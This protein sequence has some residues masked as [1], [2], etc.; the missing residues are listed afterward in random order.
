MMCAAKGHGQLVIAKH[1]ID[2]RPSYPQEGHY[3][4]LHTSGIMTLAAM[5]PQQT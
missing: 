2:V 1:A 3:R 4:I 5:E